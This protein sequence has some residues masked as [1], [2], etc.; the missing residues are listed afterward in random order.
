MWP[1]ISSRQAASAATGQQGSSLAASRGVPPVRIEVP[2]R[3]QSRAGMSVVR[4]VIDDV[5]DPAGTRGE[6]RDRVE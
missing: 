1:L 2:A 3:R 6:L 4:L 5:R